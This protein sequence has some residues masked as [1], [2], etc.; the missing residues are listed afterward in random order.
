MKQQTHVLRQKRNIKQQTQEQ[1]KEWS[2]R[3]KEIKANQTPQR[4]DTER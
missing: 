4:K 2:E 3:R 1:Q